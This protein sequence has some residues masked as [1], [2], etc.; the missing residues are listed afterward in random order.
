MYVGHNAWHEYIAMSYRVLKKYNLPYR[1]LSGTEER[2]AAETAT[3]S[4]YAGTIFS[5]DDFVTLSSG[6]RQLSLSTTA[7][8]LRPLSLLVKFLNLPG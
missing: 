3:M 7:A 1:T 2:V 4:S 8:S 6:L 5:L